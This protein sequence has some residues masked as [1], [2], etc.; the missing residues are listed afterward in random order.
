MNISDQV[1]EL[2][3]QS[4]EQ[5]RAAQARL[6]DINE[7]VA[8]T[9]TATVPAVRNPLADYLP[10]PADVVAGYFDFVSEVQSANREFFARLVK[11][12]ERQPAPEHESEH[13]HE[14]PEG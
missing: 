11:A 12:W 5:M 1:K 3:A 9:V 4:L 8:G 14:Q 10:K 7:R 2:Q 13:D 6:A